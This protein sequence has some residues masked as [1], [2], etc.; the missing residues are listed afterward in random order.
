[1]HRPTSLRYFTDYADQSGEGTEQ[2]AT[3]AVE[4]EETTEFVIPADLSTL[5]MEELAALREQALTHFDSVYAD[6]AGFSTEDI[7]ALEDLTS[8]IETLQTAIGDREAEAASLASQ[9]QALAARAKGEEAVTTEDAAEAPAAEEVPAEEPV[10]VASAEKGLRVNLSRAQARQ[11]RIGATVANRGSIPFS[12]NGTPVTSMVDLVQASGEG[13][14]YVPGQGVNWNDMGRIVDHR[15]SLYNARQYQ[16]AAA[17]GRQVRQTFAVATFRKP[18]PPELVAQS[19]DPMHIEQVLRHAMDERRLPQQTLVAS[20][21]WCAP[22]ET[23]YDLCEVESREGLFSL[24]EIGVARGGINR[25][26]GPDFAEIFGSTGFCYTEEE[27][28]DG[29]YD[30]AGGGSKPCYTVPCPE[31]EDIRMDV[32]GVCINAGLLQARGFPEMIAR[33]IRGAL[34]AH[35]HKM[36]ANL[37]NS[38]AAGSDAVTIA[39]TEG[40]AAPLLNAVELQVE[41][42]KYIN[43][44]GRSATVEAVFPFW[45]RGAIRSDLA[46]RLGVD[47]FDVS[48][49]RIDA[50]FRSRGIAP[51]FVYNWQDL[52]GTAAQFTGWPNSVKFL[53]YPAGTW[54]RGSSDVINL[55]T[56]Y[57]STLLGTND[58]TALFSEEGWLAAKMCH[59][60]RVVTVALCPNGTTNNGKAITCP[61]APTTTTSTTP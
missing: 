47:L 30:G 41:H 61:P 40:A 22:S 34:V 56:L 39:A 28:I 33:V 52:G 43:R 29:D 50:W 7:Q 3:E 14:G 12:N 4:A 58:Y 16:A 51:Q 1:M 27:D 9:A 2:L 21:G 49:S 53:I 45:V 44:L 42:M 11:P 5:S 15:L 20:G 38:V 24:P 31:F 10:V 54:V 59:D 37:L 8:G 48:D 19:N 18:I 6:G 25:T 13:G 17:S 23:L 60:S 46:L 35:D 36:A 55:E 32:C 26:L 57:D